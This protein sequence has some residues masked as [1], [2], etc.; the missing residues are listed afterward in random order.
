[1]ERIREPRIAAVI[2]IAVAVV[3][4]LI[5]VIGGGDDNGGSSN[6]AGARGPEAV[7]VDDLQNLPDE[8]GHPVYWGGERPDTQYE[9]TVE[10]NGN[11]F[12]RYLP[13]DAGI[14]AD[15]TVFTVGT[16]PVPDAHGALEAVAKNPGALQSKTPDGA[17]VVTNRGNPQSVY[18]AYPGSDYQIEVYDP[19]AAT[20]LRTATSGQIKPLG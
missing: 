16:Y 10:G 14:G 1:V 15:T 17:L 19:D 6:T 18:V 2:G 4:V 11:I 9:L 20:A 5:L 13:P 7:T 8:V 3:I 12:I